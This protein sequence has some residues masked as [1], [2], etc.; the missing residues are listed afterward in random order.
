MP[1]ISVGLAVDHQLVERALVAA[2][3]HVL[4]RPEVGRVG[5]DRAQLVARLAFGHADAGERRMAEHRASGCSRNRP[6]V[7]LLPKKVSAKAWPSRIATGVSWTRSVT[8]PTAKIDG[9]RR[10]VVGVDLDLRPCRRSRRRRSRSPRPST[11]GRRPTANSTSSASMSSQPFMCESQRA[12][13][14]LLDPLERRV[15][16][17]IDALR[18]RDLQQPVDASAGHSRAGS[19][20]VR[21]TRVTWLPN[22]WK[23][24]ANSLAM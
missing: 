4:H 6:G 19:R 21:L 11:L 17:E 15:E 10:A 12:V 22:W 9:T 13:V 3:E 5:L 20:R 16:L 7:G 24:P 18:Q 2:G 1:T 8:S 23:M 14:A